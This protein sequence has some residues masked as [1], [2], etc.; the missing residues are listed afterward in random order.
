MPSSPEIK[1]TRGAVSGNVF[2]VTV[3]GR[4]DDLD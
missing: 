2:C 4:E 1:F 3:G